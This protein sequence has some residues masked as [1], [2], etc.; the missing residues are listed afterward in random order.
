MHKSSVRNSQWI[1]GNFYECLSENENCTHGRVPFSGS[2]YC[3]W[4]LKDTSAVSHR[5]PPCSQ[6][7]EKS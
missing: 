7:A 5:T 1:F 3:V 2:F 6:D 4:P